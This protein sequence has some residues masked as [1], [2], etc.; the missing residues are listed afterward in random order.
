MKQSQ[1]LCRALAYELMTEALG[2]PDKT[3]FLSRL[4]PCLKGAGFV[5]A[6]DV[7]P[8]AF[9]LNISY[10]DEFF[11][12]QV[13]VGY[14]DNS[15][16]APAQ[17]LAGRAPA[18]ISLPA[19]ASL[20]DEILHG[21][22]PHMRKTLIGFPQRLLQGLDRPN[23]G[24]I[25][26][27]IRRPA[28]LVDYALFL[29]IAV[30]FCASSAMPRRQS[31]HA[32]TIE[33]TDKRRDCVIGTS[34]SGRS[35]FRVAFPSSHGEQLFG[36]SC[37]RGF[38][39]ARLADPHELGRLAFGEGAERIFADAAHQEYFLGKLAYACYSTA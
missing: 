27:P 17:D 38:V 10:F 30:D 3:P 24:L 7:E 1:Q 14:F 23:G 6:P 25:L 39:S 28:Q 12:V 15:C 18:A 26:T 8:E 33:Q 13:H 22:V 2:L 19:V 11:S 31:G 5:F 9:A 34:P 32:D 29:G 35:G 36:T 16:F 37:A 4:W 21:L 20:V